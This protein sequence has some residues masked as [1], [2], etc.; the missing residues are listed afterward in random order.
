MKILSLFSGIGA[1]EKAL[2]NLRIKHEVVNYCEIDKYASKAYSLIHS[3]P[4]EKNLGDITKVNPKELPDFDM[5]CFGFPCQSYSVAG[6]RLGMKDERGLLF[7]DALRILKEK[8]PKYFIFENVQGLLSIDKGK[9]IEHILE[10][11]SSAGYEITM[12]LI[13]SKD[14]GIPQ[15]RVRLFCLG[16]RVD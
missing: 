10:L 3:I 16:R 4:E 7:Y 11:L 13:N 1:F 14:M 8:K 15:N 5:L 12:D 6:K 9:T 2:E